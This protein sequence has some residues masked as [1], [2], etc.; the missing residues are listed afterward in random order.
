[1]VIYQGLDRIQ[2]VKESL[3]L[4]S[5]KGASMSQHYD[6][7]QIIEAWKSEINPKLRTS[8]K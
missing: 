2:N 3:V 8:S 1:V 5:S 7:R 4:P 6:E